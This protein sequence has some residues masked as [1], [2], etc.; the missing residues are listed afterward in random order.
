MWEGFSQ[1]SYTNGKST[2]FY[3]HNNWSSNK[4]SILFVHGFPD[5]RVFG[6][7]LPGT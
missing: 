4:E 5:G 1:A 7:M 3:Y 6:P 2:L